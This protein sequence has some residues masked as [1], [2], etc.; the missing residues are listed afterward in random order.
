MDAIGI[1]ALHSRIFGTCYGCEL[2][3]VGRNGHFK[4][5]GIENPVTLY[6]TGVEADRRHVLRSAQVDDCLYIVSGKSQPLS[7]L[8]VR[9]F[10]LHTVH[11]CRCTGKGVAF[12][13]LLRQGDGACR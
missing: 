12:V 5:S 7:A 6:H 10:S 13:R 1:L 3:S 11:Q 4:F 2:L 9:R 8:E